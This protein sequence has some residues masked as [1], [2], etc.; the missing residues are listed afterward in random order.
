M[1]K[2]AVA[3]SPEQEATTR[4]CAAEVQAVLDRY[5]CTI[6]SFPY[7]MADGRLAAEAHILPKK[8][9]GSGI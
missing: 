1:A 2:V 5:E 7:V 3:L 6:N 9:G 8:V 4:L